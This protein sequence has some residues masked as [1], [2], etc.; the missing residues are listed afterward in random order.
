M[1][2][3]YGGWGKCRYSR[4][5]AELKRGLTGERSPDPTTEQECSLGSDESEVRLKTCSLTLL[6]FLSF[7][8]LRFQSSKSGKIYLHRDVRLLF[9][10]K[11]MEVDSGAAYE[12]KS[13]TESP[14][15]PQFSP[16]CWWGGGATKSICSAPKL[17]RENLQ[18]YIKSE[19]GEWP[20]SVVLDQTL[21]KDPWSEIHCSKWTGSIC[22]FILFILSKPLHWTAAIAKSPVRL[23]FAHF[24]SV[25]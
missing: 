17:E 18:E 5:T 10:R 21:L 20:S 2:I 3:G 24:I 11:S 19:P 25:I 4:G 16:R 7:F 9:S 6:F 13:Y 15:N 23:V 1:E 8:I 12:L 22:V 14:T